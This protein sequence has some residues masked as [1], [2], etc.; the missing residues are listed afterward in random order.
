M[1]KAYSFISE[2]QGTYRSRIRNEVSFMKKYTYLGKSNGKRFCIDGVNVLTEKWRTKGECDIVLDPET[3]EPYSFSVYTVER[4]DRT[5]TFLAGHFN[6]DNDWV[7][8]K[9]YTE[10][11]LFF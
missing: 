3:N 1:R 11:D 5:V 8:F 9:E 2:D 6:N 7:F 4:K 10:D